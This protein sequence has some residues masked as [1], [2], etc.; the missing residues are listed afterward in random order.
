M[1]FRIDAMNFSGIE[2]HPPN[3]DQI[4]HFPVAGPVRHQQLFSADW[5]GEP[6]TTLASNLL[7][8]SRATCFA[9]R[10]TSSGCDDRR[11]GSRRQ[12]QDMR[13]TALH[14]L[15]HQSPGG[16]A[17]PGRAESDQYAAGA[18]DHFSG[19]FA[20]VPVNGKFFGQFRASLLNSDHARNNIF[21]H[22]RP[23]YARWLKTEPAMC[24]MAVIGGQ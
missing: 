10:S 11:T 22:M 5:T 3:A 8:Q 12:T 23:L 24:R 17:G 2:Q 21:A 14:R 4:I 16:K 6:L 7:Y 13:S 18:D 20:H 9:R 15:H 1:T 19:H